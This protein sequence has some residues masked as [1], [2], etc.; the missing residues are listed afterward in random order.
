MKKNDLSDR[1]LD[2]AAH[3]ISLTGE[4]EKTYTGKYIA[5]QLMRSAASSGA[6]YEEACGAESRADFL[7]KMQIVLKELKESTYWL[8]LLDKAKI[9]QA[10]KTTKALQEAKELCNIMASS[11]VTAKK[12]LAKGGKPHDKVTF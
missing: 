4:L 12:N 3:I 5:G 6:N 10:E 11:I 8:R 2:F 9:V 1:I 7:H